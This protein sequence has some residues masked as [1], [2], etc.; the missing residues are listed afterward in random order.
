MAGIALLGGVNAEISTTEE[1]EI[2]PGVIWARR[3]G[4]LLGGFYLLW[5]PAVY[6]QLGEV[7]GTAHLMRATF[8]VFL[9]VMLML[10]YGKFASPKLWKACFVTLC[11]GSVAFVFTM[12][13][14]V[15]FDYMAAAE[16][17]ERLG[18]PGFEGTL[19]F[20]TLMQPLAVLFQRRPDFLD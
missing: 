3:F 15:M 13:V 16:R 19:I 14:S 7:A 9:G 2:N 8:I 6:L 20:L 10:P 4:A 17:E 18:V 11:V 12:I 1:L 5:G